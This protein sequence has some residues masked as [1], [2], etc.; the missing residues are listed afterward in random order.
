MTDLE[1]LEQSV[2]ANEGYRVAPYRDSN[3][4]WTI[5][6]GHCLERNPL[7][8]EEW[9]YLLD[10]DELVVE[11]TPRGADWLKWRKLTA[12]ATECRYSFRLWSRLNDARQNVIVEMAYQMGVD[13]VKG[14]K[15]ML[16]AIE[17]E[18]WERAET[19]GLSSKWAKKDSPA[20][21][22]RLMTQLRTGEFT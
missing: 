4:L 19:E 11:I 1:R 9:K 15:K 18:D 2:D 22:K 21:A 8:I 13:G 5:G 6:K 10:Q 17:A 12:V 16:A 20:R 14:F 7:L 3:G